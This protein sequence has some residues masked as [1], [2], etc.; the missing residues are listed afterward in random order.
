MC[1]SELHPLPEGVRR[2]AEALLATLA[3]RPDA[4]V[5]AMAA[6]IARREGLDPAYGVDVTLAGLASGMRKPVIGLALGS[7][8]A[9]GWAHVGVL[10]T[11]LE[12]VMNA[13]LASA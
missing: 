10:R 6:L 8:S 1:G 2:V 13:P 3:A 4:Q 9:R 7:G 5:V 12:D 11:L